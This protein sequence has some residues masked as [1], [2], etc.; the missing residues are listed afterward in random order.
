MKRILFVFVFMVVIC[1]SAC[2]SNGKSSLKEQKLLVSTYGELPNTIETQ[3][4]KIEIKTEKQAYK[5]SNTIKLRIE[6]KGIRKST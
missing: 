2:S 4:M 3:N 1:L 5:K 6:N